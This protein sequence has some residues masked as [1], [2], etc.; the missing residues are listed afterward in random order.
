M[1]ILPTAIDKVIRT[2]EAIC[3]IWI[4]SIKIHFEEGSFLSTPRA[5]VLQYEPFI[6]PIYQQ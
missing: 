4:F 2:K 3:T 5:G 6:Q 1:Y